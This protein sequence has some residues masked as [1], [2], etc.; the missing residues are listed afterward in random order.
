MGEIQS[1]V[2][3]EVS[4]GGM[5]NNNKIHVL[6]KRIQP[7]WRQVRVMT[8]YARTAIRKPAIIGQVLLTAYRAQIAT[9]F[10]LGV[11]LFLAPT[12]VNSI[13]TTIFPPETANKVFGLIKTQQNNPWQETSYA[14]IM[15]MFWLVSALTVLLLLWLHLP[16]GVA[17]ADLRARKLMT[18]SENANDPIESHRLLRKALALAT[19]PDLIDE[20]AARRPGN[21]DPVQPKTM[22]ET[23]GDRAETLVTS[24]DAAPPDDTIR[25]K[26]AL[27]ERYDLGAQLGRGA[28]GVVF[29]A[30][31]RVL[32]R[33][34]AIKQLALVFSGEEDYAV[35]FRQEARALARLTHPN[36]VQVHDLIEDGNRLWMVLEYVDGGDLAGYLKEH[37]QLSAGEAVDIV[38]PMAEGLAYAHEQG[39]VHRDLKPANVLLTG[40]RVPKI[41]DFGIAKLSQA[42]SMTAV[43]TVLGSPPY[44]SPEQCS[45]GAVDERTD[46]YALGITLYELLTGAVPFAGDTSSVLARHIVEPPAPISRVRSDIPA[47]LE[48]LVMQMLAKSADDRPSGMRS[49]VAQLV[50]I[51]AEIA[52]PIRV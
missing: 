26:S 5:L 49:V 10:F 42:G 50:V 29:A 6:V 40:E 1:S 23:P 44:M 16:E 2:L 11:L 39:I 46:I 12:V 9:V 25:E 15:T 47:D 33:D 32:D 21:T 13:T 18:A 22:I 43:G 38:I 27:A 28:M 35:R 36:V 45:G 30:R 48:A 8:P 14:V 24:P 41:S 19:A 17:R 3:R 37:K 7:L 52:A 34:V 31:D 51:G 20:L 4:F